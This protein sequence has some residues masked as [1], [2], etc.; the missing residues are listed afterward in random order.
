[1]A[2]DQR[3]G[4]RVLLGEPCEIRY[5]DRQD[6]P[7]NHQLDV[8]N[9]SSNAI[10]LR[11]PRDHDITR[12]YSAIINGPVLM[13]HKVWKSDPDL[14]NWRRGFLSIARRINSQFW[15]WVF[16]FDRKYPLPPE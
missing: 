3:M 16:F 7:H 8:I 4:E 9:L 10:A 6:T 2:R 14:D 11:I 5:T 1:M 15:K 12:D 13:E